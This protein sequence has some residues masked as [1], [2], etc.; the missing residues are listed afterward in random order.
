MHR[1]H[2]LRRPRH[3]AD[4]GAPVR[5]GRTGTWTETLAGLRPGTTMKRCAT[6]TRSGFCPRP[7][8]GYVPG[9]DRRLPKP[10]RRR[11]GL[12]S[13]LPTRSGCTPTGSRAVPP[14]V[15]DHGAAP[16]ALGNH[17]RPVLGPAPAATYGIYRQPDLISR[18]G[19]VPHAG[20]VSDY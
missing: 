3:D 20:T 9:R 12:I 6:P 15:P 11:P 7:A 14:D 8:A 13:S 4:L 19:S 18:S 16:D 17:Q 2:R 1:T 5:S 10:G